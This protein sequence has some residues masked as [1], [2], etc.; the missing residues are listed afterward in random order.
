M[1]H[2][3]IIGTTLIGAAAAGVTYAGNMIA[4]VLAQAP[5]A[6]IA[7]EAAAKH[8]WEATVIVVVLLS[9]MAS[10]LGG[11]ALV[12]RW[13]LKRLEVENQ[14]NKDQLAAERSARADTEAR[15][16]KRIDTLED[17][18]STRSKE[19]T[20]RYARLAELQ[21]DQQTRSG[22]QFE[23]MITMISRT[24]YFCPNAQALQQMKDVQL[25]EQLV[26]PDQ[27]A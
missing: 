12:V 17:R 22:E 26:V 15:M 21:I 20:D 5:G 8:G 19:D 2:D 9:V 27:Q 1:L 18:L 23:R 25:R 4:N 24:P 16:A 13:M 10:L 3:L 11:V 14:D 6:D 7:I